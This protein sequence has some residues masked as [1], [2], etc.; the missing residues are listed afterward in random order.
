MFLDEARPI[1][2]D[3]ETLHDEKIARGHTIFTANRIRL[4]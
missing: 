3:L 2:A 1:A 4:V